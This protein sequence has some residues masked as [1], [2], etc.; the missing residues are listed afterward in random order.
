MFGTRGGRVRGDDSMG[1]WGGQPVLRPRGQDPVP[2]ALPPPQQPDPNTE[3]AL[4]LSGER[5][6]RRPLCPPPFPSTPSVLQPVAFG[7][8]L[9]AVLGAQLGAWPSEEDRA[10]SQGGNRRSGLQVTDPCLQPQGLCPVQ[11]LT[12]WGAQS[13][14]QFAEEKPK[15]KCASAS[16]SGACQLIS[17]SASLL[18]PRQQGVPGRVSG[19]SSTGRDGAGLA[20]QRPP[21]L[22][23]AGLS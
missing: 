18:G 9:P 11:P 16:I 8:F 15:E 3:S 7:A 20:G 1:L 19:V 23:I 12:E 10:R 6:A 17:E 4:V 21:G 13:G 5:C 2:S 22:S 14:V